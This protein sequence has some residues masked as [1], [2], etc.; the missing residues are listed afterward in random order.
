MMRNYPEKRRE[1][2]QA[3]SGPVQF[4]LLGA[5]PAVA[6][7]ARLVD[8]SPHGFRAAHAYAGL[9]AG[10]EVEFEHGM[11]RGRARVAWTR[12]T[13]AAVESGFFVLDL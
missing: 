3:A 4:R 12:V 13:A 9:T 10:Q 2:R 7:A 5:A 8:I 11:A 6:V 1:S